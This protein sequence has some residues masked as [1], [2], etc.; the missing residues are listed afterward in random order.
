MDCPIC[1][2]PFT[3][4]ET[5]KLPC[6]HLVCRNCLTNWLYRLYENQP[7]ADECPLCRAKFTNTMALSG[8]LDEYI[9]NTIANYVV[10]SVSGVGIGV[11]LTNEDI[12]NAY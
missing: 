7:T 1:G 2:E 5:I 12:Q 8:D 11:P 3:N 4:G 10:V 6:D 9:R